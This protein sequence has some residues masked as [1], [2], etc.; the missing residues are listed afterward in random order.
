[1]GGRRRRPCRR[2]GAF[3]CAEEDDWATEYLA[4]ELAVKCVDGVDAAIDHVNRYGTRHSEAIVADPQVPAGAQA[5]EAFLAR[6]DA[7]AV[8]A[9]ASTA[10]TDGGQF[11][12][13]PRSASPR[14]SCTRAARSRSRRSRRTSTFCAATGRCE[15]RWPSSARGSTTWAAT[16]APARLGIMGGTFD[17][18]HIGHLACAEQAREAFGLDGVLF[19]PAGNPVFKKDRA[20]TPAGMRLAMCRL[21]VA[22]NPAFDVRRRGG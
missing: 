11:G 6:V 16:E 7:A 20:V 17:P 10:F 1:M 2:R 4:P 22:S 19:V 18:I 15:R 21:A 3:D 9:N 12:W 8:Y 14:R 5:I 13:G